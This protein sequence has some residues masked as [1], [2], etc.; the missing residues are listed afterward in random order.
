MYIWLLQ[1]LASH[2][3]RY[4]KKELFVH[5]IT[6]Q[7]SNVPTNSL[8]SKKLAV[9]ETVL[10]TQ[11]DILIWLLVVFNKP[12]YWWFIKELCI[13]SAHCLFN[14]TFTEGQK[15]EKKKPRQYNIPAWLA[16]SASKWRRWSSVNPRAPPAEPNCARRS[17]CINPLKRR[18]PFSTTDCVK[19][20]HAFNGRILWKS[21]FIWTD[22]CFFFFFWVI[23]C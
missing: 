8:E 14:P 7:T 19:R 16:S 15:K 1:L 10:Q 2:F 23:Y 20:V 9:R 5:L 12:S 17:L 18:C 6:F 21:L 11:R 22:A 13:Y 4:P 3:S